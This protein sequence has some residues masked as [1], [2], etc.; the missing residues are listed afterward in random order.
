MQFTISAE[1]ALSYVQNGSCP[2]TGKPFL[3]ASPPE[4]MQAHPEVPSLDRRSSAFGYTK[5]N[6]EVVSSWA[7]KAKAELSEAEFIE[8]CCAV[9][10]KRG[11][12]IYG[13]ERKRP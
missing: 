11:G 4:G 5:R 1:W 13:S 12:M 2:Y 8:R 6:T 3:I 9:A 7:N 10:A